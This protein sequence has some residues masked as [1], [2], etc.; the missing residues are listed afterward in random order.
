M[1][2]AAMAMAFPAMASWLGFWPGSRWPLASRQAD[3][4]A[5]VGGAWQRG[6]HLGCG[7]S[8]RC[9]GSSDEVPFGDL[10]AG[11]GRSTEL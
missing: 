4:E 9:H 1:D 5:G 3:E 8:E 10:G 7:D 11:V 6:S 2:I